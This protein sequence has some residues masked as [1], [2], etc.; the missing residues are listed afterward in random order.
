M[1][2]SNQILLIVI[3]TAGMRY[4]LLSFLPKSVGENPTYFLYFF[5]ILD[6]L[7]H[8]H[9]ESNPGPQDATQVLKPL[10]EAALSPKLFPSIVAIQMMLV[11]FLLLC[12][13]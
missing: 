8:I 10:D 5:F 4:D 2:M 11:I 7:I 1:A 6:L 12:S 3:P 9:R 13:R